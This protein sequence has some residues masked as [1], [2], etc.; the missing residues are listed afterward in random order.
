MP[1]AAVARAARAQ[2]VR[3]GRASAISIIRINQLL[4]QSSPANSRSRAHERRAT[5]TFEKSSRCKFARLAASRV[6][7]RRGVV[8]RLRVNYT[9]PS[10]CSTDCGTTN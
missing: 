7:A 9:K 5:L 4:C 3:G 2:V 6:S 1:A 8:S 10:L